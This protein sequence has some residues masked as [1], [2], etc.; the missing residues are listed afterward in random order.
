MVVLKS[1]AGRERDW[2]DVESVLVRQRRVLRWP[3]VLD[4]LQ[5]LLALRET[6]ENLDKL[7]QLRARIE[8]G[9]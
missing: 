4:E 9:E 7:L 6:P 5:P 2:L 1:F 3:L 8:S